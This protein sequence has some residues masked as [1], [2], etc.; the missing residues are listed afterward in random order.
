MGA[1]A[2]LRD[3]RPVPGGENDLSESWKGRS[4]ALCGKNRDMALWSARRAAP[5]STDDI[6]RWL[7]RFRYDRELR[8]KRR[9]PIKVL[10]EYVG[11]HRDTLYE[12]MLHRRA[13][14]LVRTKLSPSLGAIE[15]GRLRFRRVGKQWQVEGSALP[16]PCPAQIS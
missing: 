12:V 6:R 7:L 2:V 14:L 15:A 4:R 3:H 1:P 10:A 16:A 13:S 11:L 5:L 9:I 8:G